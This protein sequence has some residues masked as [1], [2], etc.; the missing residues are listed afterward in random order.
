[1]PLSLVAALLVALGLAAIAPPPAAHGAAYAVNVG[2]D[3]DDGAC[4][5]LNIL[6][7]QDCTLREAI[8]AANA[9][10]GRHHNLRQL[11][12]QAGIVSPT[13]ALPTIT[14]AARH[15]R[16]YSSQPGYGSDKMRIDGASAGSTPGLYATASLTVQNLILTRFSG[17]G[18]HLIAGGAFPEY[19]RDRRERR[20]RS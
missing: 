3:T 11:A 17:A 5:A 16:R 1:V 12:A 18:I 13:S 2:G 9:T 7:G 20:G 14:Q 6:S 19:H 8:N 10:A 15:Q 4:Q